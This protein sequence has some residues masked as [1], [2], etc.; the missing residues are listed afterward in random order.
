[1][2]DLYK[3]LDSHSMIEE[4]WLEFEAG[5]PPEAA[6]VRR[7]DKLDMLIQALFYGEQGHELDEFFSGMDDLYASTVLDGIFNSIK[8]RYF[9]ERRGQ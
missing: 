5:E 4:L 2:D 3:S 8:Q 6:L 1:M 9:G 7:I